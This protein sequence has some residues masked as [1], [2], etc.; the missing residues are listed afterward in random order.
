MLKS[1]L[2]QGRAFSFKNQNKIMTV[3]RRAIL[4]RTEPFAT[5]QSI[6]RFVVPDV[7]KSVTGAITRIKAL[8]VIHEGLLL[9]Y[10]S[11]TLLDA[12]DVLCY[13]LRLVDRGD[14]T[15]FEDIPLSSLLRASNGGFY[16]EID[17]LDIELQRCTVE[18]QDTT[19]L[20][21]GEILCLE[22]IYDI[23]PN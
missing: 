7:L 23:Y 2:K 5:N 15:K 3:A 13:T 19:G 9:K 8:A 4:V 10:E 12:A 16:F 6:Y 21:V 17:N 1:P 14:K 11:L 18:V 22:V 20:T